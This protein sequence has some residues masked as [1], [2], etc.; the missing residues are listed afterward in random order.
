MSTVFQIFSNTADEPSFRLFSPKRVIMRVLLGTCVLLGLQA[1]QYVDSDSVF[2]QND[3]ASQSELINGAV[4]VPFQRVN[5]HIIV[6]LSINGSQPLRFVLDTGAPVTGI[7]ENRITQQLPL[8]LG[9]EIPIAGSGKGKTAIANLLPNTSASIADV[10]INNLMAVWLPFGTIPYVNGPDDAY[11]D[12]FIGRDLLSRY[13]IEIDFD[14][15]QI[16][17]H[18]AGSSPTQMIETEQDWQ[19]LA[20]TFS[21]NQHPYIKSSVVLD[22]NASVAV[23]L[24]LDTGSTNGLTLSP[25]TH[26]DIHWPTQYYTIEKQGISGS[27]EVHMAPVSQLMLADF[28]LQDLVSGFSDGWKDSESQGVIGNRVLNRFNLWFDYKNAQLWV[29]PHNGLLTSQSPDAVGLKLVPRGIDGAIVANVYAGSP[30]ANL[31]IQAGD[32]LTH[33][34]G[35]RLSSNNFDVLTNHF[36]S[37]NQGANAQI[38][39]CWSQQSASSQEKTC[40]PLML[41]SRL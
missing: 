1:C 19:P 9:Q 11:F 31:G 29:K 27:E 8:S 33:I 34:S 24:L 25:K 15:Q 35:Q 41:K 28:A 32:I 26:Q 14:A 21:K 39:L 40:K 37:T 36:Y 12:G 17:L 7:V 16:T 23:K 6:P 2:H 20:L 4:T 3:M 13:G 22:G 38:Q 5:Q 30:A 18:P 10:N